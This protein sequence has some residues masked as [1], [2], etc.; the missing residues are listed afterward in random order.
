MAKLAHCQRGSLISIHKQ[1]K[2]YPCYY[3]FE[4]EGNHN[5]GQGT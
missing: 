3:C 4:L 1:E 2:N 5:V